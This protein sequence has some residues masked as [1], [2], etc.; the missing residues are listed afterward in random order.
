MR[1][2]IE[3]ASLPV[4]RGLSGLPRVVPFLGVL[5][6]MIAGIFVPGW[7]WVL[8]AV[9]TLFLAWLLYLGWPKTRPSERLLRIAATVLVGAITL[10]RA[11]P[12]A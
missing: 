10:V 1:Q 4:V 9:V 12:Q 5:A 8:L 11:F 7:G 3:Q 6:L 2:S